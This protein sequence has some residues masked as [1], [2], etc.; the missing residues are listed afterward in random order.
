ME[1]ALGRWYN[2]LAH[3]ELGHLSI[4]QQIEP[5][6]DRMHQLARKAVDAYERGDK[7]E[8]NRCLKEM[9]RSSVEVVSLLDRLLNTILE[10]QATTTI[11]PEVRSRSQ[12]PATQ[13]ASSKV[14]A[15]A[16]V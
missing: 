13:A 9:Q 12:K 7:N 4:F 10:Q 1:C 11:Q 3:Q 5:P 6:H 8:A 15:G 2:G 14:K 16:A